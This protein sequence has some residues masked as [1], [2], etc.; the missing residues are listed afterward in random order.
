[1]KNI[2]GN[3]R[4]SSHGP[5]T[6]YDFI[7]GRGENNYRSMPGE[8][9]GPLLRDYHV[10]KYC[11][12]G[13]GTLT[14]NEKTFPIKAGQCCV[15]FP[16]DVVT[17]VADNDEPWHYA[18]TAFLGSRAN[19]FFHHLGLSSENP[20]FPWEE[21][22]PFLACLEEITGVD[23]NKLHLRE[24]K[25]VSNAYLLLDQLLE[26]FDGAFPNRV[27]PIEGYIEKALVYI[28]QNYTQNITVSDIAAHLG[29][30]RSY[31]AS[32]FR[33]QM[34]TTPQDYLVRFRIGR[35]C[36]LF[37]FP[38]ATVTSVA[39][40]LNYE[41]SVFFRHFKRIVGISPSEYKRRLNETHRI[42]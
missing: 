4:T 3:V 7:T 22:A 10:L 23:S 27:G 42:F 30:N 41:P 38:N 40:S 32:I 6:Q 15:I 28:E 24:T 5:L 31:F 37:A 11:K 29:L 21:N 33:K 34:Q 36:E 19:M 39:N 35:A 20:L 8:V 1:M 12:S 17:E 9:I 16:G 13:R 18:Y 25:R 2:P 14:I 26:Y